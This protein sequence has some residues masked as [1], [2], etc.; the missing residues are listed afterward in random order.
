GGFAKDKIARSSRLR[1]RAEVLL[2]ERQR[3]APGQIGGGLVV[4][5]GAGGVVE[6][7]LGAGIFVEREFFVVGF[8]RGLVGFDAFIDVVVVFG[9]LQ[10]QCRLDRRYLVGRRLRAVVGHGGEQ[11]GIVG[12]HAVDYA[13]AEAEADC[14]DLAGRLRV[15][16]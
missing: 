4:T 6:G 7:M 3:P 13:A 8:Q 16:H 14:A 10:Q 5:G 9:V 15:L 11:T 2:K 12:G 1:R